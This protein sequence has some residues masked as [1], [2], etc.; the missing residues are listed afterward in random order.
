M[1]NVSSFFHYRFM[2]YLY[3]QHEIMAYAEDVR[4]DRCTVLMKLNEKQDLK[5]GWLSLRI[6]NTLPRCT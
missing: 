4:G 1:K 3:I 2:L 5:F 6:H